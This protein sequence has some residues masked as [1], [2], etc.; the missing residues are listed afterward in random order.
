MR[1]RDRYLATAAGSLALA[2][3]V[4]LTFMVVGHLVFDVET[5]TLADAFGSVLAPFRFGSD[6]ALA[7]YAAAVA[8]GLLGFGL[9][10]LW[11][12]ALLL[13]ALVAGALGT[14]NPVAAAGAYVV[15]RSWHHFLHHD[16]HRVDE[17]IEWRQA[18]TSGLLLTLVFGNLLAARSPIAALSRFA[19]RAMRGAPVETI[20][21]SR[22]SSLSVAE[23][24][25]RAVRDVA[26]VLRAQRERGGAA[27]PVTDVA[28][29]I[30]ELQPQLSAAAQDAIGRLLPAARVAYWSN[31]S[32]FLLFAAL[33]IEFHHP[34]AVAV[35]AP[36]GT[37]L[38]RTD[39]D[40]TDDLDFD[41]LSDPA[42]TQAGTSPVLPDSDGDGYPDGTEVG[43]SHD[44]RRPAP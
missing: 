10:L 42:E 11:G 2:I 30:A 26:F 3:A 29:P 44:P 20:D 6:G 8:I 13:A 12:Y 21:Q 31:G 16:V 43:T 25:L 14:F 28:Q 7:V 32:T 18:L 23:D 24:R 40:P 37:L 41:G 38:V 27:Y 1:P 5:P 39:A 19:S 15:A 35:T 22:A 33:P 36:E 34:R 4:G 9:G 17:P